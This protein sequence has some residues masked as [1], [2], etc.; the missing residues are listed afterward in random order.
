M[1]MRFPRVKERHSLN[2]LTTL[3]LMVDIMTLTEMLRLQSVRPHCPRICLGLG[4]IRS[5]QHGIVIITKL[6]WEDLS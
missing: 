2:R 3:G 5:S 4:M 6:V 1:M